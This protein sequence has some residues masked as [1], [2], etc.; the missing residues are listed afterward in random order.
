[1]KKR[2]RF[3]LKI[4]RKTTKEKTKT[5][6]KTDLYRLFGYYTDTWKIFDKEKIEALKWIELSIASEDR[7]VGTFEWPDR[8]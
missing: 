6:K 5:K 7:K 2:N 3:A 1:M 8:T 4:I